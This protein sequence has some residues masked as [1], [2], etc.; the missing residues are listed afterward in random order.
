M[1]PTRFDRLT[2][3]LGTARSRRGVL[4][5]LGGALLAPRP[6]ER[7]ACDHAEGM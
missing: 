1:D 5:A 7:S 4:T 3:R 2:K 6:G